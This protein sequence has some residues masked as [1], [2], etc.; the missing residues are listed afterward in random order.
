MAEKLLQPSLL[1]RAVNSPGVSLLSA[2]GSFRILGEGPATKSV[3][4]L[5]LTAVRTAAAPEDEPA[6]ERVKVVRSTLDAGTTSTVEPESKELSDRWRGV[7]MP[8]CATEH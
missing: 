2:G 3:D 4:D 5:T 7:R 1:G 8:C 6:V